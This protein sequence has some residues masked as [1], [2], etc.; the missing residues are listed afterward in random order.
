MQ[1]FHA[2]ELV[3]ARRDRWRVVDARAFD[4]CQLVTVAGAAPSNRGIERRLLAPFDSIERIAS[5]SRLQRA[6]PLRWRRCLQDLLRRGVPGELRATARANIDLLP[7]QLQP[8]LAVVH[9]LGCRLLL[10]DDV[11][12]GKTIQAGA[13]VSEL[14]GR[15]AADRV[16]ILTPPGLREQWQQELSERFDVAADIVDFRAVRQRVATLRSSVNP[17][18]TWPVAIA[19]VDY[20][21]RPEVLRDV[22][23][24]PWDVMIVDEAHRV[25]NDGDRHA[26]VSALASL[27]GYVALLTATPHNGDRAAFESLCEIGSHGDRL[28]I[29]RRSR[30]VLASAVRRRVHRLLVRPSAEERR[31][32]AR[33][34]DFER[35]VRAE[36]GD[37]N[38]DAW[39]AL[40][41]L[42][43]RALSSAHSLHVSIS[44]RLDAMAP[45]A[46]RPAQLLL[47][48]DEHGELDA[49]DEAPAWQPVLVLQ[50]A[51]RERRLLTS[52]AAAAAAAAAH[53]TKLAAISRLLRR[54]AEPL[55]IFTEYRDTL[56][57]VARTITEPVAVL[58]GGLSRQERMAALQAF[59][60]GNRRILLATDAAGEGLN[61]HHLCRIV[62]NLE[63]PW[64]PMRLE[65][66]I[67]RVDRIGQRRTVHAFHLVAA[68]TAEDRLL[69]E[70]RERI[71][72]AQTEIGTP[73]PFGEGL[74]SLPDAA[75]PPDLPDI[76]E[77][78]AHLHL[79]RA[80]AP[81]GTR[82]ARP[83]FNHERPVMM[84]AR[85]APTRARLGL[86][87]LFL[88]EAGL[89][90]SC[91][92]LVDT[93]VV[94]TA[95][96]MT[97]ALSSL[98]ALTPPSARSNLEGVVTALRRELIA[99][100]ETAVA[101]WRIRATSNRRAFLD[102]RIVRERAID[103]LVRSRCQDGV[104]PG[105]FDQRA[106]H[107]EVAARAAR[108]ETTDSIAR[109]IAALESSIA[110]TAAT[111]PRLCLVL[112][113]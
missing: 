69:A 68:G 49:A 14:R 96:T 21:K 38:R 27:A 60:G 104:Q 70:L 11:G 95:V 36:R 3:R 56:A 88:W 42:R 34:A 25:A 45:E 28:L 89:E 93:R 63:L 102:V 50:D 18:T 35:A 32:H 107:A 65:Q 26:A 111:P 106:A 80:L 67:G 100:V 41:V 15:G 2:G 30:Q 112:A 29:F 4:G 55:I 74:Q 58:H 113:P 98:S 17:W 5:T 92:R 47:P 9:G 31:M 90:D 8:A 73:D 39:I 108:E 110:V 20:I 16:L 6:G 83:A 66:R 53:E 85:R 40:A 54:I 52:A 10:A 79:L 82:R 101:A 94:A 23:A 43:K 109:R 57:H 1:I 72:H 51:D 78:M 62:I 61:L 77:E 19:S 86:R 44:R 33:L 7:H 97:K 37:A 22:V 24:C 64:N 75:L 103:A 12:L 46:G 59:T 13:I 99:N 48:L 91:G 76:S 105:L 87:I 71:V 81:P 84:V